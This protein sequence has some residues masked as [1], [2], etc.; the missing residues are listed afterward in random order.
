MSE[1]DEKAATALLWQKYK[2]KPTLAMKNTLAEKYTP[3]V[4][5]IASKFVY[6]L[7][8]VLDLDDI[9]Q[10]GKIGLLD[11][12]DRYDPDNERKA[13]FQTYAVWRIHGSIVDEINSMD[14]T[15]RSTRQNIKEVL[16]MRDTHLQ[17]TNKEPTLDEI[18]DTTGMNL[19]QV[20][21]VMQQIDKTYI[22]QVDN[23]VLEIAG[24]VTDHETTE[25]NSMVELAINRS[26]NPQ[27]KTFILLKFF[28]GYSN[29]EIMTA[30]QL[31]ANELKTV[32]DSAMHKLEQELKDLD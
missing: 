14:W 17:E 31:K 15:P 13:Q 21:L 3:L 6:K 28:V 18:S 10:A 9:V 23:D 12:I 16:R 1:H 8:N 2:G 19:D 7:P 24:P 25:R 4:Y 26:L 11:A 20:K 29:K 5:K 22:S 30:M 32:K 27:E